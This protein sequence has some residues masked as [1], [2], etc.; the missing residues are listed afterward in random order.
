MGPPVEGRVLHALGGHRPADLLEADH[1]LGAQG[2]GRQALGADRLA[3]QE[4]DHHVEGLALVGLQAEAGA[5]GIGVQHRRLVG[6]GGLPGADVGAVALRRDEQLDDAGPQVVQRVVAQA[7]V[8]DGELVQ[9][10]RQAV[11]LRGQRAVDDL[12]LGL[13]D[14]VLVVDGPPP[15][16]LVHEGAQPGGATGVDLEL[17]DAPGGVVPRCAGHVPAHR[18][19]LVGGEDLLGRD[20]GA[21]GGLGQVVEVAGGVRQAVGVVDPQGIDRSL[22]QQ[23]EDELVGAGEDL[24]VLHPDRGQGADVEE[25]PVVRLRVAD[26]PVGE[27]VVLA[28]DQHV[29]G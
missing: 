14:D 5:L 25:A 13:L 7:H 2:R 21:A 15:R 12:P 8:L 22:A 26:L 17:V 19:G 29:H 1:G 10:P 24:G 18:Q 3:E 20:P 28:P 16:Q 11:D 6:V 4:R 9:E 23:V 27:P